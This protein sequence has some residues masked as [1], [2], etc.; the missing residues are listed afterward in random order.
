MAARS[1]SLACAKSPSAMAWTVA[2]SASSRPSSS[3][4]G[5]DSGA[6]SSSSPPRRSPIFGLASA[7]CHRYRNSRTS[8]YLLVSA[9]A[10][11]LDSV[12]ST[13]VFALERPAVVAVT[14]AMTVPVV[15]SACATA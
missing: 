14:L 9:A 10:K 13:T 12:C 2:S 8:T 7:M 4:A 11:P 1:A 15:S 5:S 6:G 3:G